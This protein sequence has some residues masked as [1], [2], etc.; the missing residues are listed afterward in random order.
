MSGVDATT[1][2]G[3]DTGEKM[4]PLGNNKQ[5]DSANLHRLLAKKLAMKK[6]VV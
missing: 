3:I 1:N 5:I 6:F 2:Q 4:S